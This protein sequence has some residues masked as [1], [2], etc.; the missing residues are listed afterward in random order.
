MHLLLF[1]VHNVGRA[2]EL[3]LTTPP[4]ARDPPRSGQNDQHDPERQMIV[5]PYA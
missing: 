4:F 2:R 1:D 3:S 5:V